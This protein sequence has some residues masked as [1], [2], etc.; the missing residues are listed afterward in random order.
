MIFP[1]H[2]ALIETLRL[3]DNRLYD[4]PINLQICNLADVPKLFGVFLCKN[5]LYGLK[6]GCHNIFKAVN[7]LTTWR[8]SLSRLMKPTSPLN[9][10][11]YLMYLAEMCCDSKD[12]VLVDGRSWSR[13]C[14]LAVGVVGA[15][16]TFSLP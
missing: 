9:S 2:L 13:S 1:K 16:G 15:V 14:R 12:K 10:L 6:G 3:N 4:T 7:L 5:N 11:K 8:K